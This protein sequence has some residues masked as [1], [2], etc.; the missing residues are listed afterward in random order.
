[1]SQSARISQRVKF[2]LLDAAVNTAINA[3]QTH[4]LSGT[5]TGGTFTVSYS[6]GGAARTSLPITLAVTT[7]VMTAGTAT[8]IAAALNGFANVPGAP[9]LPGFTVAA[10]GT[11]VGFTATAINGLAGMP[12]PLI[13]VDPT[14]VTPASTT[15][16]P[17][18][19]TAGV[20]AGA[21]RSTIAQMAVAPWPAPKLGEKEYTNFDSNFFKEWVPELFDNGNVKIDANYIGD[22]S[23]DY[24]TGLLSK[25]F[26]RQIFTCI[27]NL[28]D[29]LV[30]PGVVDL[31]L[32]QTFSG[33]F[34][35]GA[36]TAANPT[37][38]PRVMASLRVTGAITNGVVLQLP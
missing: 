26:S 33:F 34:T 11:G 1:M 20:F 36:I 27:I 16:A 31:G 2:F 9:A 14:L 5:P 23:Q 32:S 7:N 21:N 35:E 3:V 38:I 25:F 18:M 15:N 28:P 24:K 8:A 4:T 19:T 17:V 29:E 22:P 37:D 10:L 13:V 6:G 12:I 30:G